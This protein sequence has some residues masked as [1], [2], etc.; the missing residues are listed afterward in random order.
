M[1]M[2]TLERSYEFSVNNALGG[3]SR[4]ADNREYLL[5]IHN[6]MIGM[7]NNPWT[8]NHCCNAVA[9]GTPGDGINRWN[10]PSDLVWDE[11]DRTPMLPKSWMVWDLPTGGQYLFC[12]FHNTA[13]NQFCTYAITYFSGEGLFSGGTTIDRP[14]APDELIHTGPG[15]YWGIGYNSAAVVKQHFIHATD[16]KQ[17]IIITCYNNKAPHFLIFGE[18]KDPV[19][20]Y[21]LPYF[22]YNYVGA[23]VSGLDRCLYTELLNSQM[24]SSKQAATGDAGN[25]FYGRF[26]TE[27]WN[28]DAVG[29]KITSPN[30]I[31]GEWPLTK[32]GFFSTESSARGRHGRIADLWFTSTAL[33]NGDTIEENPGAPTWEFAVFGDLVV[34]W[35][36]TIP[37]IA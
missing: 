2:P 13:G 33:S 25:P 14:T 26:T 21:T 5:N 31:S 12:C 32:I 6:T 9:A 16:G 4:D 19:A 3:V 28:A 27:G 36:G 24:M 30:D 35:N 7:S 18:V 11:W 8:V 17:T 22:C 23:A 34:P 37:Q 20:G 10:S 29:Q 15:Q 1:A